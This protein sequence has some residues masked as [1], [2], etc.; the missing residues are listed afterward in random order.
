MIF[1]ISIPK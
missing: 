1:H